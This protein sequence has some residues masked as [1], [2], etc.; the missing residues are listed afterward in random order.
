MVGARGPAPVDEAPALG[1]NAIGVLCVGCHAVMMDKKL[2]C[3]LVSVA[4]LHR[5]AY[6]GACEVN[7]LE[8]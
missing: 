6:I 8:E 1:S 2:Y 4:L 5:D 3:A 7:A